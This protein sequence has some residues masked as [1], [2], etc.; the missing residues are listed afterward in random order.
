MKGCMPLT[1]TLSAGHHT[2]TVL[3]AD[4]T[5]MASNAGIIVLPR[6]SASAA[7][8]TMLTMRAYAFLNRTI[9]ECIIKVG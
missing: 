5:G 3:A 9:K 1:V 7:A 8:S 6:G 2:E 4:A